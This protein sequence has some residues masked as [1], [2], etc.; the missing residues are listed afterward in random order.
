MKLVENISEKE[1][2]RIKH[3]IGE[4][5]VANELF[6]EFGDIE[7]RRPLV[8]RYMSVYVDFVYESKAL[9]ATDDGLGFIG[10]QY[11]KDAPVLPQIKMLFKLFTRLPIGKIWKL[12]GHIKQIANENKKYASKPHIDVLMV[13]VDKK[14][15]GRGDATQLISFAKEMAMKKNVPL[16]VDT[17]MKQ[18]S[19]MYRHLGFKLYNTKTA[20]NGVT[21]YNLVWKPKAFS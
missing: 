19:E 12:L 2:R 5:F 17:D 18:Y 15:Q 13:A 8:M 14:S 11:S 9:Y 7:E 3:I 16:L 6:R 20:T 1:Q 21:R 10:L 4:A